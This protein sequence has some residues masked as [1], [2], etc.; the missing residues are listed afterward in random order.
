M[1]KHILIPHYSFGFMMLGIIWGL[2]SPTLVTA[3]T[4]VIAN[5]DPQVL[6]KNATR[7]MLNAIYEQHIELKKTPTHIYRIVKD[8]LVPHID[9]ITASRW[10][11]GKH[12]RRATKEQKKEFIRQF[13]E[14]LIRFY[15]TTLAEYLETR[16]GKLNKARITFL[17]LRFDRSQ[18]D[19]TVRS[20]FYS[21]SGKSIPVH[22]HM[23]NTKRGW[24]VYDV[25]VDGVSVVTLYRTSFASEIRRHGVEGL[26][27]SLVRRNKTLLEDTSKANS[28]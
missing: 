16:K 14:L 1:N 13:R 15:S 25:T 5:S 9:F 4:P 10:V 21:P 28:Q 24:K 6:L 17:P 3:S 23:H 2:Y 8:I 27:Q 7:D 12:W 20:R 26:I 18:Q 19:V 22:Y 11:L